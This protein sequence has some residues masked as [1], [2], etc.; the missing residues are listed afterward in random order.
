MAAST[1]SCTQTDS[2]L[3]YSAAAVLQSGNG[4]L[5]T[6]IQDGDDNQARLTQ[7]GDDNTMTAT[8]LDAGNRIEWMQDGDG[9]SDLQ[10]TQTGGASIQITETNSGSGN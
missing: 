8:Q 1:V 3:L 10:I 9:L 7:D 4:N 6:L 2:S 5:L